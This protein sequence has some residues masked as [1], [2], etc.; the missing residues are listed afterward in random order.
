MGYRLVLNR[1]V[2]ALHSRERLKLKSASSS[3]TSVNHGMYVAITE[4]EVNDYTSICNHT[5]D[6]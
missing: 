5:T 3:E 1:L 6:Q 4:L 2:P